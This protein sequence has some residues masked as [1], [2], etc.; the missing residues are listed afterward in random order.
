MDF[1]S[2]KRPNLIISGFP[3]DF[4]MF[5]HDMF[6]RVTL[7]VLNQE[8]I[9]SRGFSADFARNFLPPC[10]EEGSD[11]YA[12]ADAF[13]SEPERRAP[14]RPSDV[15]P[16][17]RPESAARAR[18]SSVPEVLRMDGMGAM[19]PWQ[20]MEHVTMV[21]DETDYRLPP[22]SQEFAAGDHHQVI[23]L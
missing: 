8:W 5:F 22:E 19:D 13:A 15:A 12:A 7:V 20:R 9:F 11:G 3:M 6:L 2:Y 21:V 17:R 18:S 23:E 1:P 14:P 16:R 4:H 10:M